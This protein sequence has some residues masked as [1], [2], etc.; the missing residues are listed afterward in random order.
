MELNEVEKLI[1]NLSWDMPEEVQLSAIESL[2][3][4]DDEHTPLLIQDN[5]KHCWN[6]AVKVLHKIGYPRNR[7]AIPRLIWLMQDMNWP[8]VPLAIEIMKDIDRSVLVPHIE[9]ALKEAVKYE[10]FMWVGGI[11]R[12]VDDLKIS[13]ADFHHKEVYELLKLADW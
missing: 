8:G 7:L 3:G 5:G 4:I 9:S 2:M 6:N 11:Q 13:K 10:D 12:L 1:R